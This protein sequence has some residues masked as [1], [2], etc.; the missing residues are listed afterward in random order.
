MIIMS[1]YHHLLRIGPFALDSS[2]LA[3]AIRENMR[4]A[5]AKDQ[6]ESHKLTGSMKVC[7]V[8]T[9]NRPEDECRE[10]FPL[11]CVRTVQ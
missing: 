1:L 9:A 2:G 5:E 8:A 11:S 7:F 3:A 10:C 4:K 6:T